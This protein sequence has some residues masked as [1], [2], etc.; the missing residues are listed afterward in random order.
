M[1]DIESGTCIRFQ[2]RT[3][4]RDYIDFFRGQGCYSSLGRTTN[5][6]EISI[7]NGCAYDHIVSHEVSNFIFFCTNQL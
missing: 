1:K 5:R 7:G 2:E 3:N 4:Q 6:Q